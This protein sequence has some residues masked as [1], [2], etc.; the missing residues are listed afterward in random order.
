MTTTWTSDWS[1][2]DPWPD[3]VLVLAATPEAALADLEERARFLV[4]GIIGNYKTFRR[5]NAADDTHWTSAA[6]ETIRRHKVELRAVLKARR[7]VRGQVDR[8]Q[9]R[10]DAEA[11]Q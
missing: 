9:D 1:P 2:G 6:K 4:R 3:D 11:K 10:V 8:E 5:W 7:V